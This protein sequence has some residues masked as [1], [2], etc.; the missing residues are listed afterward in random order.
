MCPVLDNESTGKSVVIASR[1]AFACDKKRLM[2]AQ[3]FPITSLFLFCF[4]LFC[5]A[6][7]KD[8]MVELKQQPCNL[9]GKS[10]R[11]TQMLMLT[12]LNSL[13]NPV[14][15]YIQTLCYM[16]KTSSYLFKPRSCSFPT[17]LANRACSH[18]IMF[19]SASPL[20]HTYVHLAKF[21][22]HVKPELQM[23]VWDIRKHLAFYSL[24]C[25]LQ[26]GWNGMSKLVCSICHAIHAA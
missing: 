21:V 4:A 10:A 12:S 20:P 6:L 3:M 18:H 8:M 9:E 22:S 17:M 16:R 19:V 13:T 11:I 14:I 24:A 7:N 1:Q 5:F 23:G 25:T 15:A 26:R 2:T